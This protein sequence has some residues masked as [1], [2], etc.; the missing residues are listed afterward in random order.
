MLI[1]TMNTMTQAMRGRSALE[2]RGIHAEIVGLD[3][4]LTKRGCAYGLRFASSGREEVLRCLRGKNIP[5]GSV[6]GG[7]SV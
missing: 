6:L 5:W 4:S 7:E 3:P 1:V 2:A